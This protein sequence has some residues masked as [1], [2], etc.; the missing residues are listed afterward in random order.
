MKLK[1]KMWHDFGRIS[2]H[3]EILSSTFAEKD[4]NFLKT[5]QAFNL[6][7]CGKAFS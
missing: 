1:K 4:R 6:F 2:M 5:Q 3:G 7:H